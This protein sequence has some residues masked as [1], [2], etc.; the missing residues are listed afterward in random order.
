MDHVIDYSDYY[1]T[2]LVN[3]P[4]ELLVMILSYLPIRD[5]IS[6]HFVSQRFKEISEAP[7]FWKKFVWPDYE[8]RHVRSMSKLLKVQGEHVRQL[9]F[10][11]HVTPANILEMVHCCPKV[12]HLSFSRK[13]CLNLDYLKEIVHTM[14]YLEQLDVFTS[15]IEHNQPFIYR[16]KIIQELLKVTTTIKN[17][18]LKIEYNPGYHLRII[19]KTLMDYNYRDNHPFIIPKVR[20]LPSVINLLIYKEQVDECS[21]ILESWPVS[22]YTITL[23]IGLYDIATV[24]M[25]LYPSIPLRKFQFGPAATSPLIALS[26]HGILG[27]DN[28][29]FYLSNYNHNVKL[30]VNPQ[31]TDLYEVNDEHLQW[32]CISNFDSVSNVDFFGVNIYPS[33]LEQLAIACPNIERLNLRGAQNCFQSLQGLRAIIDTCQNL[34]GLNLVG[35][36]VSSVESYLLLWELLSSIKRL[37]HLAVDFCMLIQNSDSADKQKLIAMLTNCGSLKALEIVKCQ[38]VHRLNDLL[39]SHFPSL[40]YVR[41]ED[42][43]RQQSEAWRTTAIEYIIANCHW[44]KHLYYETHFY[45][46]KAHVSL[47]SLSSCHLQQLCV[48]SYTDLSA[49]LAHVLSTHGELEQVALFIRSTTTNAITTLISNSPNLVLLFIVVDCPPYD[50]LCDENG[51]QDY[52]KC[53]AAV[54]ETFSYHKLLTTGD[55][56]LTDRYW[57]SLYSIAVLARYNTNFNSFW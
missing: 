52:K 5:I 57:E 27:L 51:F 4:T 35:I 22:I 47:P 30:S 20:V 29:V 45:T 38:S 14:T 31:H 8:P 18:I 3:L 37:T 21:R 50:E 48:K 9:F 7:S 19:E 25:D 49:P 32:H 11:A 33:H 44:L 24:P 6:M 39:F 12:T 10:P 42:Y 17:L 16:D 41:L 54:S 23:E 43:V 46:S 56:I 15:I 36:P 55:F 2:S 1:W 13:I 26:D 28:D 40:V 34:Q 53:Q